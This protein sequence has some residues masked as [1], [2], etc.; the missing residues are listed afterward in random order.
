[1]LA[2][3]AAATII[4]LLAAILSNR[5]SPLAALILI[6]IA[7]AIA[8]GVAPGIPDYIVAGLA[9]I[10]PVA[11]MFVFAILFFGIMTDAGLLAPLVGAVLR[12]VGE[13][14]SRITVGTALLALLI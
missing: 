14:P 3:I 11:G 4:A 6:P 9:K 13:R 8:A 12:L 1:M 7:G 10:A 5:V 2:L